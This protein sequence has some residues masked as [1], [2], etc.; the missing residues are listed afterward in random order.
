MSELPGSNN[1]RSVD[2]AEGANVSSGAFPTCAVLS[3]VL[4]IGVTATSSAADSIGV[5]SAAVA[6]SQLRSIAEET[7]DRAQLDQK[8]RVAVIVEGEGPRALA[9][10]AFVEALQER[11]YIPVMDIGGASGQSIRVYFLGFDVRVRELDHRNM[12]RTVSTELEVRTVKGLQH[13][14]RVLGTFRREDKDTAQT[15]PENRMPV[16]APHGD[17][18]T[19]QRMLAPLIVISGAVLIIYLFFTVRS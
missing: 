6:R 15:F 4:V 18:G 1:W 13:E 2:F 5:A 10:N 11:N 16:A 9:E 19:V 17:E 3:V 14:S 12:E 7:L 8:Y